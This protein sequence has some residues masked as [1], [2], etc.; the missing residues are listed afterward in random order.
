MK[1]KFLEEINFF[2]KIAYPQC[3]ELTKED[4]NKIF[5]TL[6]INKDNSKFIPDG[7]P[8]I[9]FPIKFHP[10]YIVQMSMNDIYE[11]I[12]L[13]THLCKFLSAMH[14]EDLSRNQNQRE[15]IMFKTMQKTLSSCEPDLQ[16]V[17]SKKIK[18]QKTGNEYTDIDAIIFNK[19]SQQVYF[20]QFKYMEN[21]IGN[22]TEKGNKV[23]RLCEKIEKW[24]NDVNNWQKENDLHSYLKSIGLKDVKR[25]VKLNIIIMPQYNASQLKRLNF[26]TNTIF[27][28]PAEFYLEYEKIKD[29]DATVKKFKM[30]NSQEIKP[31]GITILNEKV[32]IGSHTLIIDNGNEE[33][34]DGNEIIENYKKEADT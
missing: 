34:I 19:K 22:I 33:C 14:P 25:N 28:T 23:K 16:T 3:R 4:I 29:I 20:T 5:D 6:V 13:P 26:D 8:L 7:T 12:Y 24:I 18:N 11:Y 32:S 9:Y 15:A 27:S 30:L 10:K 2:Q 21:Y 31:D 17:T 1:R